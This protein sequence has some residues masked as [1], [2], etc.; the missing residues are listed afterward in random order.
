MVFKA[1]ICSLTM[2]MKSHVV[3]IHEVDRAFENT[4]I[5][6]IFQEIYEFFLIC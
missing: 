1:K 3:T 5:S 6:G 2:L 4:V